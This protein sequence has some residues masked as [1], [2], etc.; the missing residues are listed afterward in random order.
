MSDRIFI[1][2]ARED[3]SFVLP[4]ATILKDRGVPVWLDQ[5]DIP[6][7]A[8]YNRSIDKAI[9]DCAKFIVVLSQHSV[10]STEVEG[11]WLMAL[12]EKKP[13]LPVLRS[14][15]QVPRQLRA[16]HRVDFSSKAVNDENS[17]RQLL[18]ALANPAEPPAQVTVGESEAQK[19]SQVIKKPTAGVDD[20]YHRLMALVGIRNALACIAVIP[21]VVGWW[22]WPPKKENPEPPPPPP[23]PAA[24]VPAPVP[25]PAPAKAPEAKGA[26]G[27]KAA[28]ASDAKDAKKSFPVGIAEPAMIAIPAG[29]FR[30]GDIQGVGAKDEL[31]VHTVQ[32]RKSFALGR[33]EVTFDE[34]DAFAK[35]TGRPL[36][37]DQGWGR[38]RRP[39]IN[40]SWE[41]AQAYAKWL[42]EQTG[43]KYRLPTEAEWEY[44]ARAKTETRYWWSDEI[45]KGSANCDGCGSQWDNKQTA[46]V[47]SFK[48]NIFGLH[49]TAG[50]VWE[51]VEDCWHDHYNGAPT[52]GRAWIGENN[53]QCG[54]RVFRGGSWNFPPVY[55]RSSFR[56]RYHAGLRDDNVGFRLA[57][58]LN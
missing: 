29:S 57:Q 52:E 31:P 47:G 45:G 5:W 21:G 38:G 50:N 39:V 35:G 49:D 16:I 56:H 17:L 58:D 33:F 46:P 37:S 20:G 54:Q 26:A 25:V 43:K 34:Y 36:P 14:P 3:E 19:D 6:A 53:G 13:I 48:A 23:A 8:N 44:A 30:M 27:E 42:S 4:L 12:D 51:W 7:T 28:A 2:Y 10:E 32:I 15:C 40:V 11:E 24:T 9:R 18:R 1:C 55:L 41:D 22:F